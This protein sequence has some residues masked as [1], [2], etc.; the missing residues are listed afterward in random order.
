MSNVNLLKL[1]FGQVEDSGPRMFPT[2]PFAI[3]NG[4]SNAPVDHLVPV[5]DHLKTKDAIVAALA[6]PS[7]EAKWGQLL[8]EK[9]GFAQA[10]VRLHDT[11]KVSR[12]IGDGNFVPKGFNPAADP[13][14]KPTPES[15]RIQAESRASTAESAERAEQALNDVRAMKEEGGHG[16]V[17]WEGT[18]EELKM[19]EQRGLLGG[20]ESSAEDEMNA[21]LGGSEGFRGVNSRAFAEGKTEKPRDIA[22]LVTNLAQKLARLKAALARNGGIPRVPASVTGIQGVKGLRGQDAA[23]AQR[24]ATDAKRKQAMDAQRKGAFD[25][26]ESARAFAKTIKDKGEVRVIWDASMCGNKLDTE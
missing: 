19:A 9:P 15:R 7:F 18:H 10:A 2:G 3:Q 4:A 22:P 21:Y 5:L 20:S 14:V 11:G 23:E 6:N 1:G 26:I 17:G 25:R 8:R 13:K 12:A 16:A 24:K